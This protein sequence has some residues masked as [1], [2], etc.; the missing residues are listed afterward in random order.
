MSKK[1]VKI[2]EVDRNNLA[3]FQGFFDCYQV[4]RA[5]YSRVDQEF[6]PDRTVPENDRAKWVNEFQKWSR[7]MFEGI[8]DWERRIWEDMQKKFGN[9]LKYNNREHLWYVE[10]IEETQN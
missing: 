4:V 5:F 6:A 8:H 7:S 10:N 9:N 1:K 3:Y 2:E